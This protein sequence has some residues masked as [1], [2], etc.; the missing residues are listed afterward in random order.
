MK[1]FNLII[2]KAAQYISE[3]D[4]VDE[5]TKIIILYSFIKFFENE[6]KFR[7]NCERLDNINKGG[8]KK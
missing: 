1:D 7:K 5:T 8:I 3:L 4:N 2:K 6:D